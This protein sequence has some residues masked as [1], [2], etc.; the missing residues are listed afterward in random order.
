MVKFDVI[1]FG[2]PDF[3]VPSL[4]ILVNHPHINLKMVVSMPDR[5]AGRGRVLKSPPVID[6]CKENKIPF[7]QTENINKEQKFL[8]ELEKNPVDFILV[9]AFAQFLGSRLLKI[10]RKGCFNIHTSLLPKY[11]GAAPIQ[12]ALLNGE[13]S[14]GV[15]IQRMVKEMDAGD[16]VRTDAIAIEQTETGGLLYTRLKFKAALSTCD[17]VHQMV[18]DDLDF[19][20][21]EHAHKTF[22]PTLKKEDGL[23]QFKEKSYAEIFNQIR[24][25]NPWPATY[26][27]LGGL[28]I[29][30]HE[31]ESSDLSLEPNQVDT[32]SNRLIIG[33]KHG[34]LRLSR[35][36]LEGKNECSDIELLNG[37][38]NKDFDFRIDSNKK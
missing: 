29:K 6:Y 18:I 1:Y 27:Y 4:E 33:C 32:S 28:R 5:P 9:L 24:A 36:Q 34:S 23:I 38:K 13:S 35:V 10:P 31:S 7:L 14:T 25:L 19:K 26:F 3:S 22:A 30:V 15:T 2:T 11:R 16:I 8:E 20:P 17:F 37:L 21:Q 12:Y